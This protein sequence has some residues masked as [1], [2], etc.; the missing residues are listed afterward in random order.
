METEALTN[1]ERQVLDLL[2]ELTYDAVQRRTGWSK[3]RIYALAL[4]TGAR[5]TENRIRERARERRERQMAFLMETVGTTVSADVLD[6]LDGIPDD[7]VQLG[8]TS[9]PFNTGKR[10]GD[11]PGADSMRFLYFHGWLM[12]VISEYSRIL[13]PGGTLF[14]QVGTTRDWQHQ[15]I[16]MD[17]LLFEDLR[18]AGLTFRNRVVWKLTQGVKS[19][20]RLT[21][22]H[23]TAL[24]FTK[25]PTHS[26]FNPGAA[27]RPQKQPSKRGYR[28]ARRG[29][30][31]GS[32]L[33]AFPVDVWD[34]LPTVRANHPDRA[35]GA[36]P[37]Q[38]PLPLA[39]RAVLLYTLPAQLV[40]DAFSG[41]GTTQVACLETGRSFTGADLFYADL[42]SRRLAAATPDS[43]TPL[44][45]VT[46]ESVAVWQAEAR[47][48]DVSA[49]PQHDLTDLLH[50]A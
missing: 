41:S 47:R 16:P 39:R 40:C 32:P 15:L 44:T 33:G 27:R 36:H 48:V 50:A 6:Y 34:D 49:H 37:A 7:S 13:A 25:G 38:F 10:Y 22:L 9:V 5:K 18:Q 35:H 14:L 23:E 30:L 21:G 45:G 3:G 29:I 2:R 19:S 12:Q 24:V 17:V 20:S 28:G 42:R 31:T 43:V 4:R 26:V 11:C 8:L 1:E 46:D